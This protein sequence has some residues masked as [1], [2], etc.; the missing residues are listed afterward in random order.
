MEKGIIKEKGSVVK[1]GDSTQKADLYMEYLIRT[2]KEGDS[3]FLQVN[4][5]GEVILHRQET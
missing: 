2:H 5:E 1:L 4:E 3:S